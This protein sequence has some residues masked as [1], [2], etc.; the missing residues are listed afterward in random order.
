MSDRLLEA[1]Y[2]HH[3]SKFQH[4]K[5]SLLV[6][7]AILRIAHSGPLLIAAAIWLFGVLRTRFKDV[8]KTAD[9]W[10]TKLEMIELKTIQK[11]R[12]TNT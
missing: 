2:Y 5:G 3:S 1:G 11:K 8:L 7:P 9:F 10:L 6:N 12:K 4:Q